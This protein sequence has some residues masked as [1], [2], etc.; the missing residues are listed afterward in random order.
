MNREAG[1]PLTRRVH[2]DG[3][4][5]MPAKDFC[6]GYRWHSEPGPCPS[7]APRD[8]VA[9]LPNGPSSNSSFH[10]SQQGWEPYFAVSSSTHPHNIPRHL[11]S[12]KKEVG[13]LTVSTIT[14]PHISHQSRAG[15]GPNP[16]P[17]TA[18]TDHLLGGGIY[19]RPFMP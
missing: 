12:Q 13:S 4:K 14:I 5:N 6:E 7:P 8:P 10:S 19:I 18:Q 17:I 16:T 11:N 15:R 1:G 2:T 3:T 9:V